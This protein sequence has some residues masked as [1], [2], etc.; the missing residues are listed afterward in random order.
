MSDRERSRSPRGS[1][2]RS[3][4]PGAPLVGRLYVSNLSFSTDDNS[5]NDAFSKYGSIK[6]CH[7]V[8][9]RF[10]GRSRGFGFVSFE[11]DADADEAVSALN[12]TELDGRTIRVERARAEGGGRGGGR[13]GFRGGRGGGFR[14]GR[15]G[16]FGGRGGGFRGGFRG[17]RGGFREGGGFRDGGYGG[18]RGGGFGGRG[19]GGYRSRSPPGGYRD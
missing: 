18:G 7:I 15:D 2:S 5:L 12:N 3:R 17:G 14:G 11:N 16:D 19:G 1:R 10:D 9:D 6:D 8:K 13:G 4:S